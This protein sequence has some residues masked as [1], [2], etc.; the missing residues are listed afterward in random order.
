MRYPAV[1]DPKLVGTYPARAH[2]GGGYVWDEVLEYRVWCRSERGVDEGD[3]FRAFATHREAMA[4]SNATT[5]AD[6]PI[7]LVLQREYIDEPRSGRYRHVKKKRI[8]EWPVEFLRRPR[9][10]ERTIVDFFARGAPANRLDILRGT[11][12]RRTRR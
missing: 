8:T 3:S 10:N 9:R 11:V 1:L 6:E 12:T 7:A 4:F 5:G 2:A